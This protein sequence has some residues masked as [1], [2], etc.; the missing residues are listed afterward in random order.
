VDSTT[1]RTEELEQDALW[2]AVCARDE[3]AQAA[4]LELLHGTCRP[5]FRQRGARVD[6]VDDLL[7]DAFAKLWELAGRQIE[8]PTSLR[9]FLRSWAQGVL[10]HHWRKTGRIRTQAE[11]VEEPDE[12][13]TDGSDELVLR[14]RDEAI[15]SC[16]E[17]LPPESRVVW[18][19]RY[20]DER[21]TREIAQSLGITPE[22]VASRIFRSRDELRR[23]VESKGV[24]V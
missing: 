9:G 18:L 4:F 14:E 12:N 3:S 5:V 8:R 2:D 19:A 23:C 1:D 13:A 10:T 11:W 6:E 7:Q 15:W 17:R 24:V 20:R 16:V 21:S 22:A